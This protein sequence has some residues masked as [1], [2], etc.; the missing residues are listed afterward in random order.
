MKFNN[1]YKIVLLALVLSSCT[2]WLDVTPIE[3]I[4]GTDQISTADGFNEILDG[5]YIGLSQDALYGEHLT[6]GFIEMVGGNHYVGDRSAHDELHNYNDASKYGRTDAI[7]LNAYKVI[8]N[9]NYLLDNIDEKKNLFT[10]SEY[11]RIKAEAQAIRAFLH[12]DLLRCFSENYS[13][14]PEALAIP[15][16]DVFEKRLFKHIPASQVVEKI[17]SDLDFAEENL[18]EADPIVGMSFI[19]DNNVI[20]ERRYRFNYYAILAIK[21]RLY[22]YIGEKEMASNYAQKV[23]DE[24]PFE[25]TSFNEDISV[26][27]VVMTNE[28]VLMLDVYNLYTNASAKLGSSGYQAGD[29]FFEYAKTKVFDVATGG[30]GQSD[31]R[32]TYGFTYDNNGLQNISTKY[33][34]KEVA[35]M[36]LIKITEMMLIVAENKVDTDLDGAISIV[37]EVRNRRLVQLMSGTFSKEE[38]QEAIYNEFRK[39]S[40]LEGQFFFLNKRMKTTVL[41]SLYDDLEVSLEIYTFP[42]PQNE[43]EFGDGARI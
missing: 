27:D 24:F 2:E 17:I 41:P 43:I 42:M 26:K 1:I 40:Y 21:A 39:E 12:F 13:D 14:A 29:N 5:A 10:E 19:P 6:Y 4:D 36:P 30:I 28:N 3:D 31:V 16:V 15:Y 20:T 34:Y 37:N 8:G 25:W 7:F 38:V 35:G 33:A 23:I 11:L 32:F 9:L 22:Q 18:L